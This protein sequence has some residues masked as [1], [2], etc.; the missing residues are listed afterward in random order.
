MKI[1]V[2][3]LALFL[4]R[5]LKLDKHANTDDHN[6]QSI[7]IN[8]HNVKDID[9]TLI[10]MTLRR[11]SLNHFKHKNCRYKQKHLILLLLL[12]GDVESNP[13]PIRTVRD[14]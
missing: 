12:A 6:K 8:H 13:G 5:A 1:L 11:I 3:I 9:N 4:V 10:Y 2:L 14:R 7:I